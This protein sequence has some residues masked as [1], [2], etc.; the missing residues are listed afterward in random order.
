MYRGDDALRALQSKITYDSILRDLLDFGEEN[1]EAIEIK[2]G[3][4]FNNYRV[5]RVPVAQNQERF[6]RKP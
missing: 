1:G 6:E 2:D 4:G 5:M 3:N